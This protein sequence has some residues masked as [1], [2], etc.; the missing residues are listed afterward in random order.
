MEKKTGRRILTIGILLIIAY[1]FID[2]I[3]Y[4]LNA[5][6]SFFDILTP[7]IIGAVIAFFLARPITA[8]KKLIEK[9]KWKFLAK[10]SKTLSIAIVYILAFLVIG[11]FFKYIIPLIVKNIQELITNA[12][13]YYEYAKKFIE[14]NELLSSAAAQLNI[15]EW[16]TKLLSTDTLNKAISIVSGI[17]DSFITSFLSI[18]LS[19]YMISDKEGIF[20]FFKRTGKLIFREKF[21]KLDSGYIVK[22]AD[23]FY[24]YFTGLALDAIIVG[25]ISTIVFLIFRVPYAILLGL[26]VTLGNLIPFFGSIIAAICEYLV[27]AFAFGPIGALWIPAFQFI[28]GQ[29]DGNLLQPKILGESV[30]ISPILVLVSVII[31]GDLFGPL[32]MILGVPVVAAV[33]MMTDNLMKERENQTQKPETETVS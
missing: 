20:R 27:G 3:G 1:K 31:F 22:T 33:K 5:V 12:P 29:I 11:L 13:T 15:Y 24:S 26:I 18:V 25:F 2:N 19:I 7:I 14:G 30:G 32:G 6:G 10:K 9:S 8:I 23:I 21:E 28:L 4:F 16:F 17:A